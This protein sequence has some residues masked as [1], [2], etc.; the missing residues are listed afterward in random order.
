MAIEFDCSNAEQIRSG[1]NTELANCNT[2][3]KRIMHAAYASDLDAFLRRVELKTRAFAS[4]K[5][6]KLA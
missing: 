3:F 1:I 5:Y 2:Y 4:D 6:E